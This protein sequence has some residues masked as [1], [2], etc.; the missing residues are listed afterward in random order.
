M[1]D[2][3]EQLGAAKGT[4]AANLY[5]AS[6]REGT[7]ETERRALPDAV[8]AAMADAAKFRDSDNEDERAIAES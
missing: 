2:S 3:V 4:A 5:K 7:C 6:E 8:K 1:Y